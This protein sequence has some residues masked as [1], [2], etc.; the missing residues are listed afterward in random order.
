MISQQ[1]Y[2]ALSALALGFA[3]AGLLAS[4]FQASTGAQ[5]GFRLLQHGD[6]RALA[7]IPLLIFS[8]PVLILRNVVRNARVERLPVPAVML[9][10][11]IAC[12]WSILCG[13]LVLDAAHL[14]G[15]A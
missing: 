5:L 14:L 6:M 8:A 15:F 11:M 4:G 10:T 12:G 2:D 7:S 3:F 1:S 13:R 9:S